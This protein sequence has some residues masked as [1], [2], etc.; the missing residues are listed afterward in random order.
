MHS[1]QNTTKNERPQIKL[2]QIP[3]VIVGALGE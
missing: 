3:G 2:N 1:S